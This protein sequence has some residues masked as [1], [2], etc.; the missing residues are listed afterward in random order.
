MSGDL[1]ETMTALIHRRLHPMGT[2]DGCDECRDLARDFVE[3]ADIAQKRALARAR[4]EAEHEL[5]I[6]RE[7]LLMVEHC[8]DDATA[9][10][11]YEAAL[12]A[13]NAV[14]RST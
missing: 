7:A 11:R 13:R 12:E 3:A 9:Q 6:A 8:A 2:G 1:I 5:T 10:Q 4:A 14:R